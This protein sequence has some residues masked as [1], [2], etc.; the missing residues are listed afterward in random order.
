M[1]REL[2]GDIRTPEWCLWKSAEKYNTISTT[3]KHGGRGVIVEAFLA[4]GIGELFT[5]KS[6]FMLLSTGEYFRMACLPQ[7]Q[8]YIKW[9]DQMLFFNNAIFLTKLQR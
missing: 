6:N 5:V 3:V 9:N 1:K 7:M 2:H 8:S 4:A